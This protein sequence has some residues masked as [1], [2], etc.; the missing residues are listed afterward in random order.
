MRADRK[1]LIHILLDNEAH[2]STGG[3]STVSPSVSFSTIAKGFGYPHVFSTDDI[4]EFRT[5]LSTALVTTGPMF[6]HFKIQRGT[7]KNLSRPSVTP[8]QVKERLTHY[9]EKF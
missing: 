6:I 7:M 8:I 4:S 3:Q 9:L 2:D 5:M 1:N